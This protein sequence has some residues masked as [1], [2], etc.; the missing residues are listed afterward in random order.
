[1]GT[2]NNSEW[3]KNL[4]LQFQDVSGLRERRFYKIFYSQIHS[5]PLLVLGYNPGGK[6]DGSDLCASESYFENWEHDIVKYRNDSRYRM[7]LPM[8]ML[9]SK[10]LG[11]RSVDDLRQVPVSNVIFRRSPNMSALKM[12]PKI[13]ALESNPF[14]ENIINEVNPR[15][16]LLISSSAYNLF[17]KY[18][19]SNVKEENDDFIF[20][21]NGKNNACILKIATARINTT[22]SNAR[23][24]MIGH[25]SKYA[26]RQE[27]H[28]VLDACIGEFAEL[29]LQPIDKTDYLSDLECLPGYGNSL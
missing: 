12:T 21:P 14:V 28:D 27:W 10:C 2:E 9:L 4:D 5:F 26:T 19:C 8:C 3:M 13:A 29:G 16:I 20:T 17:V 18:Y 6:T 7:A 25:P 22:Q 1:M 11:T 15:I 23:L 24:I